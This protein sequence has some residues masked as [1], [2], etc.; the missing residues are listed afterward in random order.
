MI[1]LSLLGL[2]I[3]VSFIDLSFNKENLEN[4]KRVGGINNY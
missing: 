4:D 2:K 3:E 1:V